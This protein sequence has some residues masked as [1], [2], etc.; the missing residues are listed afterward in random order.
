M[1]KQ[2]ATKKLLNEELAKKE[3]TII[4][5]FAK[6]YNKIKRVDE[7]SLHEELYDVINDIKRHCGGAVSLECAQ[8]AIGRPLNSA[9]KEALGLSDYSSDLGKYSDAPPS[10]DYEAI[11]KNRNVIYRRKDSPE[12]IE[13]EKQDRINMTNALIDSG[14]FARKNAE[15]FP[16]TWSGQGG[17]SNV[18]R[19]LMQG[20][21]DGKWAEVNANKFLNDIDN[22]WN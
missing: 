21:A 19:V 9:E 4:E 8:A 15:D 14:V 5:S 17:F 11:L 22:T 2:F 6:T 20:V 10:D 3:K 16:D 1:K 7:S 13:N 18:K 12:G